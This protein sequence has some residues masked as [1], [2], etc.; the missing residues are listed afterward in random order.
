[1]H[2]LLFPSVFLLMC[3]MA[4]KYMHM[5]SFNIKSNGELQR[6]FV[7]INVVNNI[8]VTMSDRIFVDIV[9]MKIKEKKRRRNE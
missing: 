4:L 5:Y 1:M 2:A 9:K 6:V 8:T 3:C 7:N